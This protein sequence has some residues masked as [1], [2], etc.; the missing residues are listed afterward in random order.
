MR[1]ENSI[2]PLRPS[3]TQNMEHNL[4]RSIEDSMFFEPSHNN[5][6][7]K[8]QRQH[9]K[10]SD[11]QELDFFDQSLNQTGQSQT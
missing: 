7:S 11:A 3:Q 1:D 6:R 9:N 5:L 4:D 8:I 2:S 10:N